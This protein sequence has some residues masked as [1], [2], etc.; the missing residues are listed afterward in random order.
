MNH[1]QPVTAVSLWEEIQHCRRPCARACKCAGEQESFPRQVQHVSELS[2]TSCAIINSE[3]YASCGCGALQTPLGV[4]RMV[5]LA[6]VRFHR[7]SWHRGR[8]GSP[9]T[10]KPFTDDGQYQALKPSSHWPCDFLCDKQS[11]QICEC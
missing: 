10:T 7:A 4:T 1:E 11:R 6:A 9:A 8:A 2:I 3:G 5:A